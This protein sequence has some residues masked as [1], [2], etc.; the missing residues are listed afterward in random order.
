MRERVRR[1]AKYR[2][3][4]V[5]V[6]IEPVTE[7]RQI[8][9]KEGHQQIAPGQYLAIGV[10]GEQYAFGPEVFATYKS[11]AGRAG[12]YVK[13]EEVLVEAVRLAFPIELHRPGWE[14]HGKAG[15]WLITL[16]PDDQYVCD[17][18]IFAATYEPVDDEAAAKS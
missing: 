7:A 4:L 2:K 6:R 3:K 10:E 14:H 1:M 16:T 8:E 18:E 15:D 11:L 12:Y 5:P 9:T 13:R 17:A